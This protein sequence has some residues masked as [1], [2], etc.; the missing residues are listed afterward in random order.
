MISCWLLDSF[1]VQFS[2]YALYRS[3]TQCQFVEEEGDIIF[4]KN[5]YGEAARHA[6]AGKDVD[7]KEPHSETDKTKWTPIASCIN[8]CT[9]EIV[10]TIL[11]TKSRWHEIDL[12]QNPLF[13]ISTV[14]Y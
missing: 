13:I 6:V 1:S 9:R 7:M 12:W 10:V 3:F 4:Y 14:R 2:F 5:S 11:L 8:I